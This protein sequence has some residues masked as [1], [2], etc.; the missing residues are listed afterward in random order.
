MA[1]KIS[2]TNL[3]STNELNTN[4][5]I[6]LDYI[7]DELLDKFDKKLT[8]RKLSEYKSQNFNLA[9]NWKKA[10][11]EDFTVS[12]SL[13]KVCNIFKIESEYEREKIKAAIELLQNVSFGM[14][15]NIRTQRF[16][17]F[18]TT[19]LDFSSEKVILILHPLLIQF[20]Q[21]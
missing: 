14:E 11:L 16:P 20:I 7:T 9:E 4:L 1:K 8:T 2:K 15:H 19:E 6:M 3:E 21:K 12:I 13:E 17:M 10:N 5:Q 18:I